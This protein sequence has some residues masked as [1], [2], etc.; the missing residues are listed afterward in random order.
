MR[1]LHGQKVVIEMC[2]LKYN[3]NNKKKQFPTNRVILLIYMVFWQVK[4][5]STLERDVKIFNLMLKLP[6][7]V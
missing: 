5:F 6:Q 2:G 3:N 4:H 7:S 1:S